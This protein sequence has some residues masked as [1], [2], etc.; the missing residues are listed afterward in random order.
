MGVA[1]NLAAAQLSRAQVILMFTCAAAAA[2]IT[3]QVGRNVTVEAETKAR[4]FANQLEDA[5]SRYTQLESQ[6]RARTEELFQS[7]GRRSQTVHR[8]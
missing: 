2:A 1:F 3:G 5:R 8:T 7:A 4:A 6:A